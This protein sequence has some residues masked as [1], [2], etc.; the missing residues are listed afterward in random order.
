MN[1]DPC[2][3]KSSVYFV[4]I[5]WKFYKTIVFFYQTNTYVKCQNLNSNTYIILYQHII[6]YQN[7][8]KIIP[9]KVILDL[10]LEA[11]PRADVTLNVSRVKLAKHGGISDESLKNTLL[12]FL[13]LVISD[14][15]LLP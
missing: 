8:R 4:D 5:L 2:V 3:K 10:K 14:V 15:C 13:S 9:N 12:D 7:V 6:M 11:L 1:C